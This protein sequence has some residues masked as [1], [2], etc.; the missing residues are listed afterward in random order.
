MKSLLELNNICKD[1]LSN[2]ESYELIEKIIF[3]EDET[4]EIGVLLEKLFQYDF[5]WETIYFYKELISIFLVCC[6]KYYY[7]DG[8]G[9]FWQSIQNLTGVYEITK[10]QKLIKAFNTVLSYN[11]LNKFENYSEESYKNIAPIIAHSGLPNNLTDNLLNNLSLLLGQD[12][13]YNDIGDEAMFVFR[14]ASKNVRRYFKTLNQNGLLN[15]FI[16]DIINAIKDKKNTVDETS[17]LPISLQENII[18]WCENQSNNLLI[19]N[20]KSFKQPILKYPYLNRSV[21][22]KDK[23]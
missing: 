20:Y 18:R 16:L 10:R 8:E 3:T 1:R 6:A 13:S 19:K 22:Q 11:N 5:S 9:G 21:L 23:N 7:N 15:D 2:L 14:Y 12:I 17:S 4:K